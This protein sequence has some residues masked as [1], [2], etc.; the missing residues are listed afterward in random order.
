MPSRIFIALADAHAPVRMGDAT[1]ERPRI[2][3]PAG[4]ANNRH[5][6]CPSSPYARSPDPFRR[7][8]LDDRPRSGGMH[9]LD[10]NSAGRPADR[11]V[12][13]IKPGSEISWQAGRCLNPLCRRASASPA[14]RNSVFHGGRATKYRQNCVSSSHERLT[15]PLRQRFQY[16]AL[17]AATAS[18]LTG[19]RDHLG[20][21]VGT[22]SRRQ[23]ADQ[24]RICALHV[25]LRS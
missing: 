17:A 21:L 19:R 3:R 4:A 1:S 2:R 24:S 22:S 11:G 10:Q 20:R 6:R 15:L 13:R 14:T 18:L 9:F 8:G 5:H 25:R 23:A 7:A 16:F 12:G